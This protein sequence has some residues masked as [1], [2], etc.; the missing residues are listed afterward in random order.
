M[1]REDFPMLSMDTIYFDNGATSLKPYSVIKKMEEYYTKYTSNIHR[2]DYDAAQRT[3]HEYDE[4]RIVVKDFINAEDKDEI[5]FT[6]G[7]T[8]SLNLV[9]FG[10]LKKV[11]KPGDEIL[12]NKGE[13][14]SNLLPYLVLQKE[15]G[16]KVKYIPLSEDYEVTI[17]NVLN[18]ITEKTKVIAIAHISNVIGDV[19]PITEIGKICKERNIYYIVDES[20]AVGHTKVDA[21]RDNISFLAFSGHKMLGPTGIGV[22]Y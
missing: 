15:I 4:T 20:Q 22:L 14:A 2:G 9:A 1:N 11:L 12:V 10:F 6:K 19:R 8:E 7:S 16:I 5:V 18:S 17:E 21:S 13:H 3:N